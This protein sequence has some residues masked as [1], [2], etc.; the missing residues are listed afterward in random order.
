MYPVRTSTRVRNI[1]A[2]YVR[3]R[4]PVLVPRSRVPWIG[5]WPHE[6][7]RYTAVYASTD[8]AWLP[9]GDSSSATDSS[10]QQCISFLVPTRTMCGNM[11][12]RRGKF[13]KNKLPGTHEYVYDSYSLLVLILVNGTYFST[14][15]Q[16][17]SPVVFHGGIVVSWYQV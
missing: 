2:S 13:R 6:G 4:I 11:N 16:T 5:T 1:F 14:S 9:L 17:Y 12:A 8:D 10:Q 7:Y 3:Y 15:Y